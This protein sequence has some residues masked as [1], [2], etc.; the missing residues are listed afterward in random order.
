MANARDLRLGSDYQ[1]LRKL[2][3]ESGGTLAIEMAKGR[4]VDQYVLVY[5][6]RGIERLENGRP[7]YR[8]LHRVSI[9][10]PSKYPAPIAPPVVQLLT[11]LYHPHVYTNLVVCM[12]RWQTS[13]FLD[14][15]ALRLGALLQFEREYLAIKDPANEQAVEWAKRNRILFP[16]D[17]CTFRNDPPIRT[18]PD[19]TP[20]AFTPLMDDLPRVSVPS[21]EET[22]VLWKDL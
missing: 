16:T 11:P 4:P 8:D 15:F 18:P 12:G 21:E 22:N 6:C 17:T 2:A 14:D 3:D 5:R 9:R 1:H 19:H 20:A 7:V 10:L 13:E